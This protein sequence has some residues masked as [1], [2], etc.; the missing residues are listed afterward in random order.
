[1]KKVLRQAF[2]PILENFQSDN[3]EYHYKKSHRVILIVMSILFFIL[4]FSVGVMAHETD[5]PG[6]FIPAVVFGLV[7][8]VTLIVG[9]LGTEK[10]ISNM[11][12]SK[13]R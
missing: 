4:S 10:E 3:E 7:S 11:W 12:G 13:S 5:S 9:S 8:L 6:Y 2:S 1:M